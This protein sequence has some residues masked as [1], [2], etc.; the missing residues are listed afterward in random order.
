MATKLNSFSATDVKRQIRKSQPSK[1]IAIRA[2]SVKF[3]K[4]IRCSGEVCLVDLISGIIAKSNEPMVL[5]Y[6]QFL[7]MDAKD[8][9]DTSAFDGR[10]EML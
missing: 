1:M 9:A 4:L 7:P 6:S 3:S 2:L 5:G 8:R 10:S